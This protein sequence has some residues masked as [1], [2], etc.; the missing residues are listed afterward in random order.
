MV[1]V[2]RRG[3]ILYRS[4]RENLDYVRHRCG[5]FEFHSEHDDLQSSNVLL[6]RTAIS[7]SLVKLDLY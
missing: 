4:R 3:I 7:P 1:F 5:R 6:N 2:G